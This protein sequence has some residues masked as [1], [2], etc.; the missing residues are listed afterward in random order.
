MR[1]RLAR[2]LA[3]TLVVLIGLG[4]A[5]C[6]SK[7]R[8]HLATKPM[9]EQF[10]LGEMLSLLIERH[11]GVKVDMTKG[12]GGGT[13]NIQPALLA[14]DFD[15][16]PEYTGTGWAYVLKRPGQPDQKTM[17]EGLQEGYAKMGLRWSGLYGFNNTY[18]LA[19]R[20]EVAERHNLKTFS[21]LARVAPNL[22]FG[23]EYD[24]F[25]R[26]DGYDALSRVYGFIFKR[27]VDMDIGLKYQALESGRADVIVVF[28]T[29]G[30]LSSTPLV[31]LQDDKNFFPSYHCAT[32]VREDAL[33]RFP[34]L[35]DALSHMDNILT[36]EEMASL[37]AA[38]EDAGRNER[39]VAR[40][41]LT[42]KGLL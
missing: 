14:G 4:L 11:A 26:D 10:I 13:G 6:E 20:K 31:V 38:V 23:A 22:V 15:L 34:K 35:W 3:A 17:F 19:V 7:D 40:E 12:V 41:F 5:A 8:L 28:T 33:K 30:K 2:W 32:V 1:N 39:D 16:Y 9:T 27:T 24:F 25:E 42:A 21:D 29:D 37:N 18:S 36:D